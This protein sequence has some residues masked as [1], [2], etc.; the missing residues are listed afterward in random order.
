MAK[1]KSQE[2]KASAY[3]EFYGALAGAKQLGELYEKISVEPQARQIAA[4][5]LA[6]QGEEAIGEE[7]VKSTTPMSEVA[8]ALNIF[9]VRKAQH[10]LENLVT[11]KFEDIVGSAPNGFLE[12]LLTTLTP[13]A[14]KKEYES[15][16]HEHA[17][18]QTL[19]DENRGNERINEIKKYYD[20]TYKIEEKD[21]AF[22][23]EQKKLIKQFCLNMYVREGK[24]NK[25]LVARKY[26]EIHIEELKSFSK[27]VK[28]KKLVADYIITGIGDNK[29][30]R[31]EFLQK[32]VNLQEQ[33]QKQRE[34]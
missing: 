21:D 34:Q 33:L 16:A 19:V 10:D 11:E 7:L 13:K 9:G 30:A 2:K 32:L 26:Q 14:G 12:N 25:E 18:Y 8:D 20:T 27:K 3:Q 31:E 4:N 17:I 1:A 15:F 23:K 29:K 6:Q 28:D 22:E 5:Y 24:E